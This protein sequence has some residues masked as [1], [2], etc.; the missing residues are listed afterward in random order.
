MLLSNFVNINVPSKNGEV[1]EDPDNMHEEYVKTEHEKEHTLSQKVELTLEDIDEG[2]EAD[3]EAE[4]EEEEEVMRK[5]KRKVLRKKRPKR[6]KASV[7]TRMM[8]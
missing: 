7:M 8:Q 6:V 4:D 1:N 2:Y 3:N 5:N